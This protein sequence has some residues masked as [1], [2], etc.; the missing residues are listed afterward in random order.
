[1]VG[2]ISIENWKEIHYSV[3][4]LT[5]QLISH[6]LFGHFDFC[7]ELIVILMGTF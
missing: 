3:F 7:S 4:S 2:Y 6:K 1:M 5:E